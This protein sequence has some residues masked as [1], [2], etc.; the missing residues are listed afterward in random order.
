VQVESR[1]QPG[2]G[3]NGQLQP[4]PSFR[5]HIK[6]FKKGDVDLVVVKFDNNMNQG[7]SSQ[8]TEQGSI[9][10]IPNWVDSSEDEEQNVSMENEYD[11]VD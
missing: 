10:N 8:E 5:H 1:P 9:I 2:W 3:Q 7:S 11:S 4:P 6:F